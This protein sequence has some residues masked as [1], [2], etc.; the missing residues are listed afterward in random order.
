MLKIYTTELQE[1]G[2]AKL[3]ELA[4]FAAAGGGQESGFTQPS[5][6]PLLHICTYNWIVL[7]TPDYSV[8]DSGAPRRPRSFN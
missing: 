3:R 8:P 7:K 5:L 2:K 6:R 4:T 1:K